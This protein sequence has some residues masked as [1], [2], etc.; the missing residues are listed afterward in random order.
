MAFYTKEFIRD[1]MA[2]NDKWLYRGLIAIH[3]L[4]TASE[5]MSLSTR[6]SNGV[7]FNSV[8]AEILSSFASQLKE[9]DFLSE[10]Q[11]SIARKRMSKYAGQLE[12]I[13][14]KHM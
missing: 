14:N 10:K 13:A 5:Q 1:K 11:K 12:R 8:D 2:T 9:R 6:E 7:G 3:N 4:Q